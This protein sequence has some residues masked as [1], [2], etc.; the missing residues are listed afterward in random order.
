MEQVQAW[1]DRSE[2]RTWILAIKRGRDRALF[3]YVARTDAEEIALNNA[4]ASRSYI[5]VKVDGDQVMAVMVPTD[6]V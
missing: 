1:V 3:K 4:A 6:D 2:G 5:D